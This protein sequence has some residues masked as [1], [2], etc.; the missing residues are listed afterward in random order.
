MKNREFYQNKILNGEYKNFCRDFMKAIVLK[1]YGK[2]CCGEEYGVKCSECIMLRSF[3]ME[4]EHEEPEVDWS[5]VPVDTPIL[6]R[7]SPQ[8]NWAKRHFA[9]YENGKVYAWSNGYTSF[10]AG[11]EHNYNDWNE[12][13]LAEDIQEKVD[14]VADKL[15]SRE[16]EE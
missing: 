15:L 2:E 10:S 16:D 9:K 4:E 7:N 12:A 3:F 8:N 5:K 6:V 14:M 11:N 13:K 1:H